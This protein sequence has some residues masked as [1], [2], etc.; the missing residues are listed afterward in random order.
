MPP[1][2]P[3]SG[4]RRRVRRT[5]PLVS[6]MLGGLIGCALLTLL[7][8]V[9]A[10]LIGNLDS[11]F[12]APTDLPAIT[13]TVTATPADETENSVSSAPPTDSDDGVRIIPSNTPRPT[14]TS[15][16]V[17]VIVRTPTTAPTE[18]TSNQILPPGVRTP[19]S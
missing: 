6:V 4:K 19:G 11:I 18:D 13:A 9:T 5:S 3:K 17:T 8:A 16:N 14:E 15:L 7:V 12:D 1:V 10:V 2:A